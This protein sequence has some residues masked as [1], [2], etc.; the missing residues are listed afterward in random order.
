MAT[1]TTSQRYDER[2]TASEKWQE[3]DTLRNKDERG[4]IER[5]L[6]EKHR[7]EK[8][9]PESAIRGWFLAWTVW[10]RYRQFAVRYLQK[11]PQRE[12]AE[13]HDECIH[14]YFL[15]ILDAK[16][17]DRGDGCRE[18]ANAWIEHSLAEGVDQRDG[19]RAKED[20]QETDREL[21]K[22][23]DRKIKV[24]EVIVQWRMWIDV[25]AL[26]RDGDEIAIRGVD[27]K[28]FVAPHSQ[29][30]NLHHPE[31]EGKQHERKERDEP[32]IRVTF[33]HPRLSPAG[34]SQISR[35]CGYG[36]RSQR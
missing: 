36:R 16:R 18:Q 21:G 8:A 2:K 7:N 35:M 15:R 32:C 14:A 13:E 24:E 28:S 17:R 34:L 20:G 6:C 3:E 29:L 30:S 33:E 1:E 23:G 26:K 31:R 5:V 27:A 9:K 22:A 19:G 10:F 4:L 12:R 25:F 11:E